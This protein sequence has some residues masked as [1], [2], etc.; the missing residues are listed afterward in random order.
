[1]KS[2]DV[3]SDGQVRRYN[4]SDDYWHGSQLPP[5]SQEGA[6][7]IYIQGRTNYT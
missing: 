6:Y 2:L 1:M 3:D 5:L 7:T 4:P